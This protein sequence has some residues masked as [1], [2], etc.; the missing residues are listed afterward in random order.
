MKSLTLVCY[1][2]IFNITLKGQSP[3][4]VWGKTVQ[5]APVCV[6]KGIATDL[7]E[8]VY[9]TGQFTSN[10]YE[11]APSPS[12]DGITVSK[13]GFTDIF[14]VKYDASGQIQWVR[15]AGG[16]SG[17]EVNSIAVDHDGNVYVVGGFQSSYFSFGS[18]T[19]YNSDPAPTKQFFIAKYDTNGNLQWLK[20]AGGD[21]EDYATSVACDAAGNVYLGGYFHD[22]FPLG[23]GYLVGPSSHNFFLIKYAPDGNLFW[24]KAGGAAD[25]I[26]ALQLLWIIREIF[27]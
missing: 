15:T 3:T 21:W 22:Y 17:E 24:G 20:S 19:L 8:N 14:V 1:V 12:F 4:A 5:N 11:S 9:V 26:T 13:S 7:D 10:S 27:T 18:D 6:T 2:I 25:G 16:P 23:T